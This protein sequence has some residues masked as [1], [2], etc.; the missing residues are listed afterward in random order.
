MR[1]KT[2]TICTVLL[3][4]IFAAARAQEAHLLLTPQHLKRLQRDR[5]RQTVRWL[6]FENRVQSVPDSPQRGFELA[7]YY[8]I[9][10]D[11]A[12]GREAIAW[13]LAHPCDPRQTPQILDWSGDLISE[14]E[15]AKI[16]ACQ[17]APTAENLLTA[18][19]NGAFRDAPTLYAACEYLMTVR[20][21]EHTD[22]R[23]NAPQFFSR[24][25][26]EF[27][28]SLKPAQID[29]PDWMTHIAA[30]ALVALDPNLEASQFLQ[31]WAIEDRQMLRD[32]PGVAYEF[33][34]ADPYL[35]GVG[36]QNLDPW[37]YAAPTGRLFARTNWD[38]N[39]C[40][41]AISPHGVEEQ[42][43]PSGWRDQLAR[44]G[45][46]NLLP[47]TQRCEELPSFEPN[48]SLLLW[49]LPPGQSVSYRDNKQPRSGQA[50]PAGL[51]RISPG[52]QGKVC[53]AR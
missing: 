35:P 33:L 32:G 18:L 20:A 16:P 47:M 38:T 17:P 26:V 4:T 52:A 15:R 1:L 36:Y 22:L 7:L 5:Q 6:N 34:W 10:H 28:L 29:H 12:R 23:Q 13:A 30:L 8:A 14:S 44:F 21:T 43:C 24:L 27:L 11:Q 42:N 45:R 25:P 2:A 53:A 19:Q 49:R 37:T 3:S 46:L 51:L 41:I 31:A 48:S 40:W 9:T 39:A 50:D